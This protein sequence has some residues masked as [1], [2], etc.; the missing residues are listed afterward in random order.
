MP[1]LHRRL[2]L[3]QGHLTARSVGEVR[4]TSF[5]LSDDALG[6]KLM[7]ALIKASEFEDQGLVIRTFEPPKQRFT[8][9]NGARP[10]GQERTPGRVHHSL[11]VGYL[12]ADRDH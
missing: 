2:A 11:P 10:T 3:Q 8:G 1:P 6:A 12:T 4:A 5:E 7:V 9:E